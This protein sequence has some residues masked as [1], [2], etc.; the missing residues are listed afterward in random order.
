[1]HAAA[2]T[3]CCQ[4]GIQNTPAFTKRMPRKQ[5]RLLMDNSRW[6]MRFFPIERTSD[7]QQTAYAAMNRRPGMSKSMS[8]MNLVIIYSFCV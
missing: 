8:V 7:I 6:Q 3:G 4:W 5:N 2:N 1:M